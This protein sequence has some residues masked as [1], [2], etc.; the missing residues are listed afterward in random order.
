MKMAFDATV[1]YENLAFTLALINWICLYSYLFLIN[2]KNMHLAASCKARKSPCGVRHV[3][4][5]D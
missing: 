5:T 3:Q 4:E 2:V 1:L